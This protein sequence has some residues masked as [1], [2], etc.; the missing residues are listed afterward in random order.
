MLQKN[1]IG[2]SVLKTIHSI[3]KVLTYYNNP[4]RRHISLIIIQII[5][6]LSL[7][8]KL[9]YFMSILTTLNQF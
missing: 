4:K 5:K 1:A 6:K 7:K 3:Q 2:D 9:I 8:A